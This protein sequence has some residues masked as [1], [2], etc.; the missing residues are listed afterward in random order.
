VATALK[1]AGIADDRVLLEKPADTTGSAL[2]N[3]EARR[4]EVTIRK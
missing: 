4:V 2:S 3:S 1:A